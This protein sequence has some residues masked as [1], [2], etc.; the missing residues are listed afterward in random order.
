MPTA[1][2]QTG[3]NSSI[4]LPPATVLLHEIASSDPTL[5]EYK[6]TFK[7]TETN[8]PVDRNEGNSTVYDNKDLPN[9]RAETVAEILRAIIDGCPNIPVGTIPIEILEGWVY[10]NHSVPDRKVRAFLLIFLKN[11]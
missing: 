6:L 8:V 9:L 1:K 3:R 5:A 2:K 4:L 7:S 11:A 10:P